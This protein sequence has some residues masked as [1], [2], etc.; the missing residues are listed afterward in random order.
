M[1][2]MDPHSAP[3]GLHSRELLERLHRAAYYDPLVQL[4]NRALF[5]EKVDACVQRQA[6]DHV[7]ALVDIDDFSATN[8]LMGHRF[9]DRLLGAVTRCL[10]HA[11]P[12][13]VLLA[14]V[15]AD[16]FGILGCAQ[17]VQPHR[18]LECVRQPLAIEGT[19]HKVSLTCGYVLL[20]GSTRCGDDLVK[21][22]TIA[23]KR[24]KR[25]HRGQHLRYSPQMGAEARRRARL[26]SDL[27]AAIE[28][29][30]LF[31]VYQPQIHLGHGA[32]VGLEALLR[33]RTRDGTLVPPDQF[34]PMAEHSGLIVA[35][36]QWVLSTACQA[37]R[38]LLD[39]GLAPQRMAVN[40]SMVQLRDPGF[41]E[42]VY[43]ALA[44]SGLQGQHLEL[45]I[46]ESVAVLP[47][48]LLE[49]TLSALRAR[50]ITVA[51]DD[52]GPGY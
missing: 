7:L 45:E 15:G 34:I 37:M 36:G 5:I 17:E 31:L 38:M 10:A 46:T 41:L 50:G 49:S 32:L 48:Q 28:G 47:T 30:E 25:D 14:R 27:R 6:Q 39:A 43:A 52:F 8:D 29:A 13:S 12:A 44:A 20:S 16:T 40:V 18:L 21:D 51:I 3:G 19:P 9:G 2:P 42:S 24:A 23:L 11:L 35:L 26:L 4:P 1:Q 22:A 33:W